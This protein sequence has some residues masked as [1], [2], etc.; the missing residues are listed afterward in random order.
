MSIKEQDCESSHSSAD[1]DFKTYKN[2]AYNIDPNSDPNSVN[3]SIN[4][5]K[6]Q[7]QSIK[8][9]SP[10]SKFTIRLNEANSPLESHQNNFDK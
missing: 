1:L 7:E 9:R 6:R 5:E 3:Q 10:S 8:S 2:S 4:G